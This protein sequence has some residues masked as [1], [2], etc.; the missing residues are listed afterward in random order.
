MTS[1]LLTEKL[2]QSMDFEVVAAMMAL[3]SPWNYLTREQRMALEAVV[4]AGSIEL[5]APDLSLSGTALR[6]RISRARVNLTEFTGQS[7]V[8]LRIFLLWDRAVYE[9]MLRGS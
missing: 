1:I 6:E 2:R 4:R 5:A 7:T 9:R 3:E 8:G